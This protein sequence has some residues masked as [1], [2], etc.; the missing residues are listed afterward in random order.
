MPEVHL[1]SNSSAV[2]FSLACYV[3]I[4]VLGVIVVVCLSSRGSKKNSN[5]LDE[6]VLGDR[7]ENRDG[8]T[9]VTD[10]SKFIGRE[11]VCATDL[12]PAG[13]IE[14]DGEPLDVVSEGGFVNAG[15][16]VKVINVDGSRVLVRRILF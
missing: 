9:S 1:F 10:K 3:I 7:Q 11:G 4:A 13:T 8:Y 2:M 15:D 6:L 5:M 16:K 12:R 14:V